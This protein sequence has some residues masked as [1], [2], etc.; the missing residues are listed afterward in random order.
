MPE[1]E[2][3]MRRALELAAKA[4]GKTLPNP[5]VGAVLVKNSRVIGEGWHAYDGGS[6]AEVV[7]INSVKNFIKPSE[8]A[9]DALKG[10]TMYI[11]LEPC[12]TKGRTGACVD[13]I[14]AAKIAKVKIATLDPN[15]LHSGRGVEILRALGVECETGILEKDARNMNFIFEHNITKRSLMIAMKY[16]VSFDGK[17]A[18]RLGVRTKISGEDAIVH[19]MKLRALFPAIGVGAGTV[20]ADDPSLTVRGDFFGELCGVRLVFDSHLTLA[21]YHKTRNLKSFKIFSD[22]FSEKTR[23]VCGA[24][25]DLEKLALL[26]RMGISCMRLNTSRESSSG[27]GEKS[28]ADYWRSL[29]DR[30]YSEGICALMV[31]GG[32]RVFRSLV[33]AREADC[34]LE[35][36]SQKTLG[37]AALP[38]LADACNFPK[39][40]EMS[41]EERLKFPNGDIFFRKTPETRLRESKDGKI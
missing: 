37:D 26:E 9:A 20:V 33:R 30:L 34:I 14:A 19:L 41:E 22:G 15:P 28:E 25:A 4:W 1:D 21:D 16:A 13:A 8:N 6:H 18:E 39:N 36:R 2:K 11:T 40:F 29:K 17:I 7:C 24:D 5:M 12:S 27:F 3:F 35:Y 38:L 10:A 23:I 32:A 31:E